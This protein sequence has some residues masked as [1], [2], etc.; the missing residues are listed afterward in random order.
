MT[1]NA[2]TSGGAAQDST[3]VFT[4]SATQDGGHT[5]RP[6]HCIEQAADSVGLPLQY[7]PVAHAGVAASNPA[8]A[9]AS[10]KLRNMIVTSTGARRRI[11]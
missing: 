11:C 5:P 1:S 8:A 2:S 9:T 3:H 10:I 7:S 6:Q 4:Q